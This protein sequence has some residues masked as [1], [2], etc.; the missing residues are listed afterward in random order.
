MTLPPP[1]SAFRWTSEPWGA[2][3]RCDPLSALAQH[4][5]TTRQLGLRTAGDP[6]EAAWDA[7]ADSLAVGHGRIA[8]VRQVHGHGVRLLA[9]DEGWSRAEWRRAMAE[10][11]EADAIVASAPGV[12]LAVQAADC[13]PLLLADA[14]TGAV[15]AVHAGWRGTCARVAPAAIQAMAR[16][17]GT[18]PGDLTVAIGPSI[19][20]CCYEVG[21]ELL[22]RF[23]EDGH[24]SADI[25]RWF[26]RVPA[27]SALS[28]ESLRLDVPAANRDQLMAA[29]VRPDRIFACGLCTK[30]RSDVFDSFRADGASAGRMAAV[31]A[32]R[33]PFTG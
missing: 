33:Q 31:I 14:K 5:F 23:E 25:V 1:A 13:V 29:G 19:G 3:L 18:C 4:V 30:C 8:R 22:L 24:E 32:R 2:A 21:G 11:P 17:F 20:P 26:A 28:D 10:R 9:P 12:A 6:H 27:A 16:A 15:A 7:V